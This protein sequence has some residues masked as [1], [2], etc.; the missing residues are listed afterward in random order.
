M[1]L[2]VWPTEKM[3]LN[4]SNIRTPTFFILLKYR[5]KDSLTI[6]LKV[7][8]NIT[9]TYYIYVIYMKSIGTLLFIY[10]C[11]SII[12][13]L[14]K[15]LAT[16]LFNSSFFILCCVVLQHR[17]IILEQAVHN[18]TVRQTKLSILFFNVSHTLKFLDFL[19]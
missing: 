2:I 8:R 1:I 16:L 5:I 19:Q 12:L 9:H 13:L 15:E 18:V 17:K 4:C 10:F 7:E 6:K 11:F 14:R 3:E